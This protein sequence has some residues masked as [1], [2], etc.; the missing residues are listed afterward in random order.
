[1]SKCN[2]LLTLLKQPYS[3]Y[4]VDATQDNGQIGRWINHSKKACNIIPRLIAVD[5]IPHL[6]FFAKMFIEVGQEILYDYGDCSLSALKAH[7]WLA[8]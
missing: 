1:M 3:S 6:C 5:G 2:S 7:P 8:D 4:S